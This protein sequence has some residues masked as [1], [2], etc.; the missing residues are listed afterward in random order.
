MDI[1]E[2]AQKLRDKLKKYDDFKGLYLYGSRITGNYNEDSDI[3]IVGVFKKEQDYEKE[4]EISGEILDIE[5]EFENYVI[6]DFH[7]MTEE[8]LKSNYIY[9]NEIKKGIFYAA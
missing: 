2:I 1:K 7:P 3:D 8:E 9:F 6:I 5:S 4:M